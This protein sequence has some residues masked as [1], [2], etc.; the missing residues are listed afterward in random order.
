TTKSKFNDEDFKRQLATNP[1]QLKLAR[2][3]KIKVGDYDFRERVVLEDRDKINSAYFDKTYFEDKNDKNDLANYFE[4]QK[5]GAKVVAKT[6]ET[7]FDFSK[8][9]SVLEI[10][11]AYGQT[12]N[13]IKAVKR[14]GI[15][16]SEYAVNEGKKYFKDLE[17]V[18]VDIQ[19]KDAIEKI[20]EKYDLVYSCITLE[21]IFPENIDIVLTNL[22][23]WTKLN[24]WNYHNIDLSQGRDRTH[25]C[26][27]PRRWWIDKFK[28]FGFDSKNVG[29]FEKYNFF[30]FQKTAEVK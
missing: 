1:D 15:D 5:E 6:L 23:K 29:D 11:C 25:Y 14:T 13:E 19:Q 26:I 9:N 2:K 18:A 3:H 4:S 17:L 30:V 20:K 8:I 22:N 27:K 24:G 12:L 7:M 28:E 16:I 10:G 21:H